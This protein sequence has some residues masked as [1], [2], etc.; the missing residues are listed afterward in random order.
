[1]TREELIKER[2]TIEDRNKKADFPNPKDIR[3]IAEINS[4][5]L[6]DGESSNICFSYSK[7]NKSKRVTSFTRDRR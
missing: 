3:R 7:G 1:M 4:L 5:L 6:T 2:D